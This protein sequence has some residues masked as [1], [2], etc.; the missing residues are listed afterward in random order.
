MSRAHDHELGYN[1]I[2]IH[3]YGNKDYT[4]RLYGRYK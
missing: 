4:G 3:A 2:L 1:Y